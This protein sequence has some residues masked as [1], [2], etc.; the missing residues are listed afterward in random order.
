M[1]NNKKRLLTKIAYLYYI[2]SK[3]QSEIS[4]ELNIYRTS[5]SRML[6]QARAEGIV[7]IQIHDFDPEIYELESQLQKIF[8][9]KE[10]VVISTSRNDT[11]TE[12]DE[13]LAEEAAFYLKQLIKGG[14]TVG[15]SWGSSLASMIGKLKG[16][17]KTNATFVPVVGG[18][19][20]VN[21]RYHVNA[22]IYDLARHFGGESIFINAGAIQDSKM[23]RDAIMNGHDFQEIKSYWEQLDIAMFGI[24]GPLNSK[25]SS[26]RDYLTV[27]DNHN[28][29]NHQ[30]IG[31]FCCRFFDEDG[32]ILKESIYNRTIGIDPELLAKVP[33][34]IGVARSLNK[35]PSIHALLK[36]PYM[37]TLIT[38][39]E[40]AQAIIKIARL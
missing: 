31:D 4:K 26:W 15:L 32:H 23:L 3:T 19:S 9:M 2:K 17:K 18:P 6:T 35:V 20:H 27:V 24:G 29:A 37:N 21:S 39:S 11:E 14:E 40:T 28:L 33:Y 10:V 34:S 5:I 12:K 36:T 16:V 30:A 25:E 1:E 7:A 8:H 22:I 38:D 13:K